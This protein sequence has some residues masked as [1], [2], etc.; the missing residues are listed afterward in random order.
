MLKVAPDETQGQLIDD[1]LSFS[2]MGRHEMSFKPVELATSVHDTIRELEPD[3]VG[4]I[5]E[6]HI[7]ALPMVKGDASML[8]MAMMTRIPASKSARIKW[9]SIYYFRSNSLG[10]FST[11]FSSPL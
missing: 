9:L 11:T 7:P 8:R 3:T 2:R 4:R 5:I 1:L 10:H 6:W